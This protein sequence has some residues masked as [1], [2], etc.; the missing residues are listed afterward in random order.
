VTSIFGGTPR[1]LRTQGQWPAASP[2]GTLIAFV[3]AHFHE[4][5]L[6]GADGQNPHRIMMDENANYMGVAWSPTGQRLAY[7][8]DRENAQLWNIETQSLNGG[9]P[10]VAISDAQEKYNLLWTRD[11]RVIFDQYEGSNL[12]ANLWAV[13]IH[14]QTGA[15]TGKAMQITN[16]DEIIPFSPTITRDGAHLAVVKE[17]IRDDVNVGELKDKG[18]RLATP[19]RLTVSESEDFPS[20][21]TPDHNAILFWSNRTGRR[22]IYRQLLNRKPAEP[23][24]EGTDD[25]TQAEMS[26]DGRWILY[27]SSPYAIRGAPPATARL[28]RLPLLGGSPEK[29]LEAGEAGADTAANFHCPVR[30]TSQCALSR[31]QE[32]ALLF[33]TLDPSQGPGSEIAETKLG[34]PESL[35]WSISPDG[36]KIAIAS[37]DQ[38]REQI[39]VLDTRNGTES[40]IQLPHGWMVW[41]LNWAADGS[42]IYAAAQTTGYFVARIDL[43]GKTHVLLDRGR[44]QWLSNPCPSPDGRYLAFS[45]RTFE[46]NVWLLENF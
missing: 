45:Q 44:T 22:Q 28:M 20:G 19:T 31:W 43:D 27:W 1:K 2:D 38:L 30:S 29:I 21:W 5:W 34:A 25:Q 37:Q 6:M 35:E 7:I 12:K 18:L 42:A 23:W 4:I 32:G 8:A 40:N 26:P 33:F 9:P 17:H 36:S 24:I 14:P 39:R 10:S 3:T 41:N 15:V 11:G 46:S 13:S 16:W